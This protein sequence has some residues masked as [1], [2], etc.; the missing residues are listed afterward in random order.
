[1]NDIEKKLAAE[2]WTQIRQ[3]LTVNRD[4]TV[5][6]DPSHEHAE[7]GQV[8][9]VNGVPVDIWLRSNFECTPDVIVM[10]GF[11]REEFGSV[12]VGRRQDNWPVFGAPIKRVC[13]YLIRAYS[14]ELEPTFK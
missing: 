3:E 8:T 2:V 5:S 7:L 11:Q 12:I 10:K 6:C 13:D 1:M 4:L 14:H 9:H